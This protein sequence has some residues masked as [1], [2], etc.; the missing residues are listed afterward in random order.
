MV[1][2]YENFPLQALGVWKS[3][4]KNAQKKQ[5]ENFCKRKFDIY[6]FSYEGQE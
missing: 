4:F 5:E 2:N 3:F 1:T 6:D